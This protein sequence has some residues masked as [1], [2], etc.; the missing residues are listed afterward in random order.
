MTEISPPFLIDRTEGVLKLSFNRP[1]HGNAI[2]QEAVPELTALFESITTDP[3]VRVLVVRGEGANFSSGGNVRNFAL[4]LEKSVSDR[5]AEFRSRLD[6]VKG[7]AEAYLAIPVPVVAA[8]QGAVA[9]AGLLFALGADYV[10][11]DETVTFLFSHQRIG[12]PP[13][14]GVS[15]LLPR[16]V[17]QRRAAELILTAARVPADE[18]FRIGLVTKVVE[19]GELAYAAEAQAKRFARA[20]VG[21]LRRAKQLIAV[22]GTQPDSAQ[23]ASERDAIVEAV[24][25]PDFAEGVRAFLEK[26]QPTFP[27]T[28]T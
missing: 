28:S 5:R 2:P 24:G 21:A 6:A 4:M 8:C 12:L 7:M 27:S 22:S 3:S 19:S 18:A 17:G 9:G 25:E 1:D 10:L 20:P 15:L 23:L 13:D 26:R 14:G 16:V 11:A